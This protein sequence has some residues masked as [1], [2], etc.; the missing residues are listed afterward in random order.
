MACFIQ[1]TGKCAEDKIS[2]ARAISSRLGIR[3]GGDEAEGET[4]SQEGV[5][6]WHGLRHGQ[7]EQNFA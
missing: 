1:R 5:D 7:G 3:G 2:R 4:A 6:L